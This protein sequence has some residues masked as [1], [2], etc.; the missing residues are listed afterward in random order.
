MTDLKSFDNE[1]CISRSCD[2]QIKKVPS[3]AVYIKLHLVNTSKEYTMLE[4]SRTTFDL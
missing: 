4:S 3:Q 2:S 1:Q